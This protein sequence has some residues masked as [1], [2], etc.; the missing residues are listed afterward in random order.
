[1]TYYTL[2]MGACGENDAGKD[3]TDNIVA[4]S[5]DQ[6]GSLSNSNPMCGK[7]ITISQNG[8]TTTALIRDKCMG[9]ASGAIDVSEKVFNEIF[10]G[11]GV[12]RSPVTWWFN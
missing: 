1:M 10:G 3:L 12:G 8:Q 7:T 5:V 6:M 9:C 4:I 2:G 11:T